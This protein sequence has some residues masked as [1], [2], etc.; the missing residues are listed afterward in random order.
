MNLTISGIRHKII[1]FLCLMMIATATAF[2]QSGIKL[3]FKQAPLKTVL[4]SISNQ[5]KYKFVYTNE[6]KIN[7]YSVTVNSNNDD[8]K[9]MLSSVFTPLSIS[10]EIKGDQ[11]ILGVIRKQEQAPAKK[12]TVTGVIIE[13]DN[14]EPLP[15]VTVQNITTNI[16]TASDMDGKYDIVA[17][18]GDKLLFSSIGLTSVEVVVGKSALVNVYMKPDAIALSDV[19]VTGYQTISKERAT[20]SFDLI[21]AEQLEK[22]TSNIAS[23]IVGT[24]AG[25]QTKLDKDGNIM[26]Q[27]RGQSRLVDKDEDMQPL[28]VVDGFPITGDFSSINPNDVENITILKDAAAASIWGAKSANGV[29]VITTKSGKNAKKG[30]LKVEVSAFWKVSPKLDLKYNRNLASSAEVIDYEQRGFSTN[31]FG[32]PWAPVE[33]SSISDAL[34]KQYSLAVTAMNEHRLEQI[35]TEQ[36]NETLARLGKLDNSDQLKKYVLDN[37]F[38]QQYNVNI[39]GNTGRSTQMLSLMF[40]QNNGNFK[41]VSND[42]Y[43]V[44]YRTNVNI[45]KWLDF[46]FAGNF[47]M[48]NGKNNDGTYSD[49]AGNPLGYS[50]YQMLVDES[51]NRNNIARYYMPN[52]ERYVPMSSF[53][54]SDWS[55]NP[56]TEM[57]SKNKKSEKYN[58]RAQAG[59]AVK[60]IEGLTL[61]TKLQYEYIKEFVKNIYNENSYFVRKTVNEAST[62]DQKTGKITPNLPKGGILDQSKNDMNSYNWR[63]QLNFNRSFDGN[64]HFV[65]FIAGTEMYNIVHQTTTFPYTYGYDDDKL[66]VGTFPNGVGGSGAFTL[67]DWMGNNQTFNYTN[68]FK[69]STE[70][71]FSLFGNASYTYDQKYTIS[72]SYRTDASNLI[73]DDPKYRYAPFWSVGAS[74]NISQEKFLKNVKWL[75]RLGLR[76]TYGYNG[77]VDRTTSFN[78]LIN[79]N[80]TQNSYIQDY[81]ATIGSY[82]N[83]SLRW[84]K[85]GSLDVGVDFAMFTGKL[86][87]KL[88]FYNRQS[89]DLIV[90]MSI[91]SINGT[92]TQKLNAA[93][94]TNTGIEFELGTSMNVYENKIIWTGGIN[95]AYNHNKIGKLFKTTYN[96]YE[97][98]GG[99]TAAFVEGY[100][101]N[102]LWSFGYAGV[103]NKGTEANPNWQPVV[104]G[105]DGELYDFTGWTPGDG[106]DYMLN[107]GT[108]VAPYSLSLTSMFN[109]YNFEVSFIFT[110]KFGHKFQGATFNYP[111]M[112]GGSALPNALYNEVLNGDPMQVVPIP[113]DKAEE[114]YYF[115]DRFYP[116]LDYRVQNA[117]HIRCQEVYVS[118]NLPQSILKKIGISRA[119]F[120]AQGNNL[121]VIAN[122]K[123]NEDPE[124]TKSM[125]QSGFYKPQATYTF[126]INLT[127]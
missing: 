22:P 119:K 96:A 52:M 69:Y 45:F 13:E 44:G 103:V 55:Y 61:D 51:G 90:S 4:E 31:F 24:S 33:N 10:Y 27:I 110:G 88:D 98:Y 67:K 79:I 82:G 49:G 93:E 54:Y 60:I 39:A 43:N 111:S 73:T 48:V 80:G 68:K 3:D 105:K 122:N 78:P 83:P 35:S 87:G 32:G 36:L 114:R 6:F 37:P 74:W 14:G 58:V 106:R 97:L 76:A 57:E 72:G 99:G 75:D 118:Y 56:L 101:A 94:M 50:P 121:F 115:W 62:W 11:I 26:F 70:R 85:T 112:N 2:A 20:G 64:K 53:P 42:R 66:T 21:K 125:A 100:N 28:I 120:Y 16:I 23:R 117:G 59:L 104:H 7:D 9:K 123:Y 47:Y 46:T 65:S 95:F 124:Y 17:N 109:I 63:N 40:E 71:Y 12:T 29:I 5:S 91:P 113:F 127:F 81:T 107:M 1:L 8:L 102:T 19:V 92:K 41:G 34:R 89:K 86:Y 25:V 116:Y 84:E 18:A 126:G 77:N 15:G 38:T 30:D 108:K